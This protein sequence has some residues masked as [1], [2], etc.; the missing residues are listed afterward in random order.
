MFDY[1]LSPKSPLDGFVLEADG[2]RLREING[3]AL[4]S[5][6]APHQGEGALKSVLKNTLGIDLPKPGFSSRSETTPDITLMSVG[7]DQWFVRFLETEKS[8]VEWVAD[9]VG[10]FAAITDQSDSWTQIELSGISARMS[11]E[12]VL[13]VDTD[14]SVFPEGAVSRTVLEHLGVIVTRQPNAA[15]GGGYCF[16]L[17]SPRS[18]AK[19]FLHALTGSPPFHF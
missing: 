10:N 18:S 14:P 17:L 7:H 2:A 9:A 11:L 6:A 13:P 4:I 1:K 16:L 3:F 5:I 12:C 19:S 8:S 15:D